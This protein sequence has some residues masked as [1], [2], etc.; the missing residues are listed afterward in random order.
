V[1]FEYTPKYCKKCKSFGHVDGDCNKAV[2][3]RRYSVYVPK[4]MAKPGGEGVN[5]NKDTGGN[6]RDANASVGKLKQRVAS[7]MDTAGPTADGGQLVTAAHEVSQTEIR[8][9]KGVGPAVGVD[10]LGGKAGCS[11][12]VQSVSC[13]LGEGDPES[14]LLPENSGLA[15]EQVHFGLG[16]GSPA[17]VL[18]PPAEGLSA[19]AVGGKKSGKKGKHLM[20]SG[21][22][23][24][25]AVQLHS[26]DD[27]QLPLPPVEGSSLH[28]GLPITIGTKEKKKSGQRAVAAVQQQSDDVGLRVEPVEEGSSRQVRQMHAKGGKDKEGVECYILGSAS[29]E[30]GSLNPGQFGSVVQGL[31]AVTENISRSWA[32][33]CEA[34]KGVNKAL[35]RLA[36][37][38]SVSKVKL[39][40]KALHSSK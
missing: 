14:V 18:K 1:V 17:P 5:Y 34:G 15:A 38:S 32:E 12:A 2:A 10:Q 22:H 6:K 33:E 28:L 7:A 20:P 13:R 9:G 37:H 25:A 19:R 36:S 23:A 11:G 4:R 3:G 24:D 8:S 30:C 27:D 31:K 21:Q 39:K 40:G 35:D 29:T 26:E 16:K